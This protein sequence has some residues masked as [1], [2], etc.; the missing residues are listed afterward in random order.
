MRWPMPQ[1][2]STRHSGSALEVLG[3]SPR[4]SMQ[5]APQ[6]ASGPIAQLKPKPKPMAN[7]QLPA[8]HAGHRGGKGA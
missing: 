6:T 2:E 5:T 1:D 8:D 4:V 7:Q 3:A